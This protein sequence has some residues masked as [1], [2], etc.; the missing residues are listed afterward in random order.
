DVRVQEA[1]YAVFGGAGIRAR[2]GIESGYLGRVRCG[3]LDG[4]CIGYLRSGPGTSYS[5]RSGGFGTQSRGPLRYSIRADS[6]FGADRITGAVHPG[7]YFC[8]GKVEFGSPDLTT[9]GTK[10]TL[11][12]SS[13]WVSLC[14]REIRVLGSVDIFKSSSGAAAVRPTRRLLF[15]ANAPGIASARGAADSGFPGRC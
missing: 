10:E 13:L 6:W 14:L 1:V 3:I 8:Q 15:R 2:G 9:K 4:H 12:N 11:L 7:N 5:G